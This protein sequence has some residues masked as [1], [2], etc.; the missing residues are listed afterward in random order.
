VYEEVI[1]TVSPPRSD[2]MGVDEPMLDLVAGA[3]ADEIED[4]CELNSGTPNLEEAHNCLKGGPEDFLK[5]GPQLMG[6]LL[7][8]I[9]L[10]HQLPDKRKKVVKGKVR[11]RKAPSEAAL[12]SRLVSAAG[13]SMCL[14]HG[15]VPRHKTVPV[16]VLNSQLMVKGGPGV[17]DLVAK[18]WGSVSTTCDA[19]W[20]SVD[21]SDPNLGLTKGDGLCSG[22]GDNAQCHEMK[23]KWCQAA[24]KLKIQT[25]TGLATWLINRLNFIQY[26][27]MA[28]PQKWLYSQEYTGNPMILS[29]SEKFVLAEER[30]R[31]VNAFLGDA[32]V[33]FRD[34][35]AQKLLLI[36]AREKSEAEKYCFHCEDYS[37]LVS[38]KLPKSCVRCSFKFHKFTKEVVSQMLAHTNQHKGSAR[39]WHDLTYQVRVNTFNEQVIT[40]IRKLVRVP[41]HLIRN[42]QIR[43]RTVSDRVMD[44][45]ERTSHPMLK[46]NPG[47]GDGQLAM[48]KDI[49][50]RMHHSRLQKACKYSMDV[51]KSA[52]LPQNSR[53]IDDPDVRETHHRVE[54]DMKE[55]D[56]RYF[57]AVG[58][59]CGIGPGIQKIIHK[60]K[61]YQALVQL[62]PGF[63]ARFNDLREVNQIAWELGM[64]EFVQ[65][66]MKT[67][68][69]KALAKMLEVKGMC[70]KGWAS[71]RVWWEISMTDIV[72]EYMR[73]NAK[74]NL[75]FAPS[76]Q[77]FTAYVNSHERE[78][79]GWF[80]FYVDFLLGPCMN[81]INQFGG[82]RAGR[83][84][85]YVATVKESCVI[86][87]AFNNVKYQGAKYTS[88]RNLEAASAWS[89]D[90][91]DA[92]WQC[93]AFSES[94]RPQENLSPDENMEHIIQLIKHCV[95]A[96]Q[97][98]KKILAAGAHCTDL[99]ELTNS[100]YDFLGKSRRKSDYNPVGNYDQ[101]RFEFRVY[102][103]TRG[104]SKPTP[105]SIDSMFPNLDPSVYDWVS[106][107]LEAMDT[108]HAAVAANN[109]QHPSSKEWKPPTG[110]YKLRSERVAAEKWS[111]KSKLVL[112]TKIAE[113]R[114]ALQLRGVDHS[115]IPAYKWTKGQSV[116]MKALWTVELIALDKLLQD[117]VEKEAAK[118]VN[119]DKEDEEE[120]LVSEDEEIVEDDFLNEDE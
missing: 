66:H 83:K 56:G 44:V 106:V 7:S 112:E 85:L 90:L 62:H 102:L 25:Y 103:Q 63:H 29:A 37:A 115:S 13:A 49:M 78:K 99:Q 79:F 14:I 84:D 120:H 87:F 75:G 35:P 24:N 54:V 101:E 32:E 61:E 2:K 104:L 109:F 81:V 91:A 97:P 28:A 30:D 6:R 48:V 89:N 55:G 58:F 113:L 111:N 20:E 95:L 108:Y 34:D 46:I 15:V 11:T 45:Q 118:P 31:Y 50:K 12:R 117:H 41:E 93:S 8:K 94:H 39:R 68:D 70:H 43:W 18:Y 47:S 116:V 105:G 40:Q 114:A 42:P 77:G 107:G 51:P 52:A 16:L 110:M 57:H 67:T 60:F 21:L 100:L 65:F 17:V 1:P 88:L 53:I 59:D 72:L 5:T 73:S 19:W 71:F 74:K 4:W 36:R 82:L 64:K 38:D 96:G 119:Q 26:H 69:M 10:H 23:Q 98:Q 9:V 33:L 92:L 22:S 86:S 76:T 80:R 27:P 3:I